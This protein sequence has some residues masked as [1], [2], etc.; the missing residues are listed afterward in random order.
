MRL[1]AKNDNP[2]LP[3]QFLWLGGLFV[4]T[5][6]TLLLILARQDDS[7]AMKPLRRPATAA[8]Q[9]VVNAPPL[10]VTFD[11]LNDDPAAFLHQRI[12]VSGDFLALPAPGCSPFNG[13]P[14]RWALVSATLQLDARG[15]EA[16][17]RL[18]PDGTPMTIEGFWRRY[19]GPLGCGKKP[20]SGTSWYLD[21]TQI[22]Q[23]NPL[24]NFG[25][26]LLDAAPAPPEQELEVTPA[27]DEPQATPEMSAGTP[28]ASPSPT[29]SPTTSGTGTGTATPTP[30]P[31]GTLPATRP[32]ITST[33]TVSVTPTTTGTPGPTPTASQSTPVPPTPTLSQGGYP[34]PL[35]TPIQGTPPPTAYP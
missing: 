9:L 12:R 15:F 26:T 29:A 27:P 7:R 24:P 2:L 34:G 17:V 10:I 35:P 31:T 8:N 30:S 5:I 14:L 33:P 13:P 3:S 6:I 20:A 1:F 19:T 16:I 22:V 32:G 11:Q 28:T 18:I 21:V 25:S 4:L 23:P